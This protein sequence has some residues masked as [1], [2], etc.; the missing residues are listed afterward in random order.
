MVKH[1]YAIG[2]TVKVIA[3]VGTRGRMKSVA[4]SQFKVVRLLPM[5]HA[6]LQYRVRDIFS[7]QERVVSEYDVSTSE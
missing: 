6:S 2:D 1:K 3:G 7:G 4:D 5:G